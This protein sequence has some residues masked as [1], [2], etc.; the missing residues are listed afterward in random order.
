MVSVTKFDGSKQVYS[1]EK[2]VNTSMRMGVNKA[3]A[4]KIADEV[5][6]RLYDGMPTQ[7]ILGIVRRCLRECKPRLDLGLDLRGSISMLRPAPDFEHFI[8]LMLREYGYKVSANRIV[9]GRCVEH[10]ID[11]V[12]RKKG[13]V[14]YVEVKHHSNPHTYTGMDVMKEARATL[15]D[16]VEG[17]EDG[18]NRI[19]FNKAMV[20]CNTKFSNH[21]KRYS[22]CRG[23]DH[24]AWKS[25]VDGGLEQRVREK[26]LYPIT[27][28]RD[29]D[30]EAEEKLGDQGIIL[31]R[32]LLEQD[33][34]RLARSS[35]IRRYKL[36][37]LKEFAG[38]VLSRRQRG[39]FSL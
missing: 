36:E 7:E 8:R 28:F 35:G 34:R 26:E 24:I 18:V 4:E 38:E 25:P 3:Q 12:A 14:V 30:S 2:V 15:E 27:M 33:V 1:R 37:D 13:E 29:L 21:A 19:R 32:Q 11:G 5:E 22:E 23:I 39:G 10:E 20:I 9:R 6:K 17:A 16:L 31:L